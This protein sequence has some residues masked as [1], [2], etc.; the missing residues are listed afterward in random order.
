ME[1]EGTREQEEEEAAANEKIQKELVEANDDADSG[2]REQRGEIGK[3]RT[4]ESILVPTIPKAAA[5]VLRQK[6]MTRVRRGRREPTTYEAAETI[7]SVACIDC[8]VEVGATAE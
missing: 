2:E 4:E 7:P 6:T 3:T 1:T 5:M 8:L